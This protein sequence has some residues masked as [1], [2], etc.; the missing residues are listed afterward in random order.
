MIKIHKVKGEGRHFELFFILY[1]FVTLMDNIFRLKDKKL[2]S[3]EII[4]KNKEYNTYN[5]KVMFISI[6]IY[7][8]IYIYVRSQLH[9]FRNVR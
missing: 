7:I 3:G 9:I 1:Y 8:N 2:S 5:I 6:Y 4:I